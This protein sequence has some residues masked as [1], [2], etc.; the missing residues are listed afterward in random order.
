MCIDSETVAQ[1]ESCPLHLGT[2]SYFWSLSLHVLVPD[3]ARSSVYMARLLVS[4]AA[5]GSLASRPGFPGDASGKESAC[6]AGDTRDK[7]S[8]P[9]SGRSLGGGNGKPT[10]VFLPGES[11]RQRSLVGYSPWGSQRVGHKAVTNTTTTITTQG[12]STSCQLC[13]FFQWQ[14]LLSLLL[15]FIFSPYRMISPSNFRV[16]KL[17]SLM[18]Y[19]DICGKYF[20]SGSFK[21]LQMLAGKKMSGSR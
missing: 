8:I 5:F 21:P 10:P 19:H 12:I 4:T 6:N 13:F 20:V 16:W 9:G 15:V 11:H 17:R 2:R 7:V 14:L 1:P 18:I 3:S